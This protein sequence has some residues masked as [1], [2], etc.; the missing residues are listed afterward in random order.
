MGYLFEASLS[1][2]R[3][4]APIP[5]FKIKNSRYSQAAKTRA[6]SPLLWHPAN[7]WRRNIGKNYVFVI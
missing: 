2:K 6:A 7:L 5:N 3:T 1:Y 4:T